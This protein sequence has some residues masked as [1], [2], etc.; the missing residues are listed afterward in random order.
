RWESSLGLVAAV[1][2][3]WGINDFACGQSA[4][5]S[6]VRGGGVRPACS[7]PEP[8]TKELVIFSA[9]DAPVPVPAV[10]ESALLDPTTGGV[11]YVLDGVPAQRFSGVLAD[12][13]HA[14]AVVV[15]YRN[16]ALIVRTVSAP[17]TAAIVDS[18]RVV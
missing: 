12:G 9:Y 6:V 4:L 10:L 7:T 3:D 8:T 2:Q 5:P 11:E 14:A 15:P 18:L 13:R 17:R 1:P 16:A